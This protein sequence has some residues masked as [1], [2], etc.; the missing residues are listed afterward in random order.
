MFS[1]PLSSLSNDWMMKGE[2][3]GGGYI[4]ATPLSLSLSQWPSLL[5]LRLPRRLD[6]DAEMEHLRSLT[7]VSD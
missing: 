4:T 2:R 5:L 6:D 7:I 3:G 1:E